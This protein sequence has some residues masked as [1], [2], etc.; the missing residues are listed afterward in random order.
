MWASEIA[1]TVSRL[2]VFLLLAVLTHSLTHQL[3]WPKVE[4][5]KKECHSETHMGGRTD[6]QVY[7]GASLMAEIV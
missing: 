7:S 6:G 5:C 1:V 3:T 4:L 2:M